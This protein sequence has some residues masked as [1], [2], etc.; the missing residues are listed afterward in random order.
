V[1]DGDFA[2]VGDGGPDGDG[3]A[4]DIAASVKANSASDWTGCHT[5][6]PDLVL[7]LAV[8]RL[9]KKT[10]DL[11]ML[12]SHETQYCDKKIILSHSFLLTNQ[13]KL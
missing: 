8:K 10:K 9:L 11:L 7:D 13:G 2:V 5:G 12:Y 3:L 4:G 1:L 6:Q